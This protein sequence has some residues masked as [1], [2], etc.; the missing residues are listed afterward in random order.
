MTNYA[1]K[2]RLIQPGRWVQDNELHPTRQVYMQRW[3]ANPWGRN[4]PCGY[5]ESQTDE[6]CEGC[7]LRKSA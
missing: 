3:L 7:G 1:C 5:M 6:R 2:D 4:P